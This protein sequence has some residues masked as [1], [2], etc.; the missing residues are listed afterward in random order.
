MKSLTVVREADG[1][2]VKVANTGER[3]DG[4]AISATYTAKYD[5]SPASV[6]GTGAPFDTVS[7]KKV[8]DNTFTYDAKNGTTKYH[9]HGKFVVSA[10][11][12]T[13]TMKAKGTDPAGKPMTV[14]MVFD[15]Q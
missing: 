12:K 13:L 6:S 10:D 5:G 1:D 8:N 11:G 2:G 7:L 3:S 9:V 15:K 4:T 14:T